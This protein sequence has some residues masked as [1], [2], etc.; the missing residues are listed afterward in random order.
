MIKRVANAAVG[1]LL[2][3]GAAACSGDA[4]ATNEAKE[5]Q[6]PSQMNDRAAEER[7]SPMEDLD[8][9]EVEVLHE[10]LTVSGV[11]EDGV[12][13]GCVVLDTGDSVYELHGD[14]VGEE[15]VGAELVVSGAVLEDVGSYCMQGPILTVDSATIVG[16]IAEG[17]ECP[18]LKSG[19]ASF[20]IPDDGLGGLSDGT[21]VE[22]TGSV[23]EGQESFC[24]QG[25]LLNIDSV[26]IVGE[27]VDGVE[28]GCKLLEA[29]DAQYMLLGEEVEDYD[30]GAA[31]AVTG[32]LSE[33]PVASFCMQGPL[34]EVDSM[35]TR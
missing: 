8:E 25:T 30:V 7:L 2:V 17:A 26:T 5:E 33:D 35:T 9:D 34:L 21:A 20:S 14:D 22:V 31:V 16:E 13:A 18:L 1:A 12:E 3:A 27:M 15:F 4:D 6:D 19:D 11:V 24:M 28:A 23:P 29:G 10:S 32:S